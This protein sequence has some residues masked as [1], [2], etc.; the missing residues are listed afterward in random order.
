MNIH[1]SKKESTVSTVSNWPG[2]VSKL[3][4][5]KDQILQAYP[6]IVNGIGCFL[7]PP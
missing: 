4:R 6:D 3:I 5:S 2:I 7:G 1:V